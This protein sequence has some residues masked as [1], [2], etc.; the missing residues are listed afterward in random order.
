[1]ITFDGRGNGRS[2]RPEG[3]ASYLPSVFADDALAVMDAAGTPDAVG[4][5][6]SVGALWLLDLMRRAPERLRGTVFIG[7]ALP[8]AA[9]PPGRTMPPFD[10][11]PPSFEG[12][13]KYN[14]HSWLEDY[15]GFLH[16]FFDQCFSE[17]HSTKPVEDCIS[18]GLETD[19]RVLLDTRP[20]LQQRASEPVL[21]PDGAR[22]IAEGFG[23]PVLVLHGREDRIQSHVAGAELASL[24]RGRFVMLEGSG[25]IP[26]A[27][28]PVRVNL[29]LRAFGERLAGPALGPRRWPRASSRARRALF[30]SSP[31][32]LG[33]IQ[34]DLAIVR[35]LRRLH[36]DLEVHWWAQ[37]PVTRV[38]KEAGEHVHPASHAMASESQHWEE[39]SRDHDLHAFYAF[40]RMDEILLTNFMHFHDLVSEEPYDLWIG[41]E[42]W[43][44]D[45]FLHENPEL[46]RAP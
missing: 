38:L 22:R 14:R 34:R 23:K 5:G 20:T 45:H 37:H 42:C 1:M 35:E 24:T 10:E 46:K 9:P 7:P 4:V 15:E 11:R 25:H 3:S 16:F 36:P 43:E 30:I 12:W 6:L 21:D 27:R 8:F 18:W 32:G 2:D 13:A 33:H 26:Q 41:D 39:E 19:A 44:I 29:E 17:P 28:D 31:I 40:R